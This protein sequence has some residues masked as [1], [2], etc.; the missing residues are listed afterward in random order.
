MRFAVKSDRGKVREV[1]EDSYNII[2]GYSGIP[3]VF[4]IAD[5]MGG[6]NSG[7]VASKMA[8]D[9]A[10]EYIFMLPSSA[11]D[12]ENILAH[13]SEIMKK[14]NESITEAAGQKE[15]HTGMGT[16]FIIAVVLSTR[17]YIGHIGDSRVYL[18][19]D[20][21]MQRLTTDHSFVEELVKNGTLT[22]EE[23]EN[24]P[25]KNL[26]TRALGG[27]ID[28]EIDTYICDILPG[29]QFVLCTDGL[30]NMV[31]ENEI[32]LVIEETGDPEAA[33]TELIERANRYGGDDNTTV[34]V[35][36]YE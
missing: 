29:D 13:I 2:A 28:I 11:F 19:R 23:A 8:V 18:I 30:T 1:N 16:T 34:V 7:E 4:L 15:V 25:R 32:K 35:V 6:H 3:T 26:I 12:E 24:H 36:K 27:S 20:G 5:G 17:M 10:S 21:N 14:A 22:R 9:L 31:P 33:C